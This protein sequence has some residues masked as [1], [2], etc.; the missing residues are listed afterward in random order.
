MNDSSQKQADPEL[1]P[2]TGG[3]GVGGSNPLAPTAKHSGS[4]GAPDPLS[5]RYP[6]N[7][8]GGERVN[9][10]PQADARVRPSHL[11]AHASILFPS[12]SNAV[13]VDLSSG[14]DEG[15][16]AALLGRLFRLQILPY[17]TPRQERM[18]FGALRACVCGAVGA[19]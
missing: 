7:V 3:Q 9:W 18:G 15:D 12:Y 8:P 14:L 5:V 13:A 2:S 10:E 4:E 6:K 17:P 19:P 11:D 1:T 16:S